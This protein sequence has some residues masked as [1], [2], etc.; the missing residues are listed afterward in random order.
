M[1]ETTG[2]VTRSPVQLD[3]KDP[4]GSVGKILPFCEL[5]VITLHVQR[6]I[7]VLTV[8]FIV[9][10]EL[11]AFSIYFRWKY[12]FVDIFQSAD[13]SRCCRSLTR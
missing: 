8:G 4:S 6:S 7:V 5:K 11:V 13:F 12:I 3:E 9:R 1:T 2:A 10:N